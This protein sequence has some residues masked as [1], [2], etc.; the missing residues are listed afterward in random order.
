M[1][2]RTTYYVLPHE[3]G[4]QGKMEGADR[5]SVIGLN[6]QEIIERTIAL[7]R[8]REPSSVIIHHA[9]GSFQEERTYGNDPF[10]PRG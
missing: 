6:K 3:N 1:S 4:W 9:D 8:N 10:P 7:A 2:I 5:A